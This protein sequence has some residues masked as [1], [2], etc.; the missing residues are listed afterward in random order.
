VLDASVDVLPGL[1]SAA[2]RAL[3]TQGVRCVGDLL[4]T[5]PRALVDLRAPFSGKAIFDVIAASSAPIA[6]R[7]VVEKASVIP[8]R[9]RRAV[10]VALRSD[11]VPIELWWFFLSP[12]A[13]AL[14]G[15]IVAVG[16]CMP[17]AKRP[18]ALRMAHPRIVP[19]SRIGTLAPIYPFSGVP[20]ARIEAA[21]ASVIDR[22]DV[23]MLDP[24]PASVVVREGAPKIDEL[25]RDVHLPRDPEAHARACM[26][27]RVRLAW[28]E[29]CWLV[30]RRLERERALG[31]A[32]AT[33]LPVNRG[34]RDAL[35]SALGFSLT[36]AQAQA[37]ETIGA[38]LEA[39]T[40]ARVLLTGDVGTGK[41]AV[42]LAAA[43]Q[44]VAAGRQVAI[45]APTSVLA[46]QYLDAAGPLAAA[47]SA[48]VALLPREREAHA[49]VAAAARK[50][51]VDVLVG[52]HALLSE[53]IHFAKL[54]LVIVDEQHRLGVAQRLS[55]V[56]KGANTGEKLAPHLL[57]VSATPIPRTLALAL[58]GELA[59]VHLDERPPGRRTPET[60]IL[61][62]TEWR[63]VV[64][65]LEAVVARGGSAFVVCAT[66]ERPVDDDGAPDEAAS[67][68]AEARARELAKTLGPGNVALVHGAMDDRKR[69]AALASFRRGD[70][71]VLVGTTMLEVGVDVPSAVSMVIDGADRFG[72]AQ[73]HQLRGRVG[74][75]AAP[76]RCLLVHGEPLSDLARAR[77]SSLAAADDGLAVA[78][79]DLRLRG[80]GDLEGA[81]QSGEAAGFRFL[82]PLV[83]EPLIVQ[84]A[85]DVEQL[86]LALPENGLARPELAG[87]RRALAR[88]DAD[89]AA[90]D[91]GL[92]REEAG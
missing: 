51:E 83:D 42:L 5:L 23:R 41:T 28:A 80:A 86:G 82:D 55:L 1:G 60:V 70:A 8:M 85:R 78:R 47:L 76:G 20:S 75:G 21:I 14:S 17:I 12:A 32:K 35:V 58:R 73:L 19:A 40:P 2:V 4:Q 34:A 88:F 24:W 69:R 61:A 71:R 74:R 59:S 62:R 72:L 31:A 6:L 18:G 63:S 49:R 67:P 15:E 43:A 79:A 33:P 9:G 13:R 77:L 7:G 57:T 48:R 87:L 37:I 52:T 25:L 65:E 11:D 16:T 53:E 84:A 29:A 3:A 81:R 10:R 89:A 64:R 45:L 22:I 50:G 44:A 90:R 56:T 36:R 27:L 26:A 38:R 30:L 68:G 91:L 92:A 66:I 46:E 39:T 54:A